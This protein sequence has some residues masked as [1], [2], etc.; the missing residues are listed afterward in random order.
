ME[1]TTAETGPDRQS[2]ALQAAERPERFVL[3]ALIQPGTVF[4]DPREVVEHPWLTEDEK[5]TVL[6]SWARDELVAEQIAARAAPHLRIASRIDAVA[7][8]LSR[9][10]ETAA[11]EYRAAACAIRRQP[12]S[13]AA[14]TS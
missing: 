1:R 5:R 2:A 13:A 11:R 12:P 6:L 7:E 14:M 8:A 4:G 3:D 9:F 10:D